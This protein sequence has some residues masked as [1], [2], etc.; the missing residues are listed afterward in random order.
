MSRSEVLKKRKGSGKSIVATA[1]KLTKIIWTLL[2]NDTPYDPLR[3]QGAELKTITKQMREI[4][5]AS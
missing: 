4:A 2:Q 3:M 1:R 5:L